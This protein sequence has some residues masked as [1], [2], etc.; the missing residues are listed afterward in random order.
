[1]PRSSHPLP[2]GDFSRIELPTREL[3]QPWFRL[4]RVARPAIY[5]GLN[6]PR[7]EKGRFDDPSGEYGVLYMASDPH[8]A[9]IE[10]FGH[11]TGIRTVEMAQLRARILYRI[12]CDRPLRLADLTGPRLAQ[13]GAD[14][15]IFSGDIAI[16]QQWSLAVYGHPKAPDGIYY[17]ARHDPSR[18]SAA[19]FNRGDM[20]QHLTAA[21]LGTLADRSNTGLLA[22]ILKSY[23]FALL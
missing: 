17:H 21:D 18:M 4:S 11:N 12:D 8:C 16:S 3:R 5:W 1:M 13:V 7:K 23:R 10:T 20:E 9:F 14:S 2:P 22:E 15:L 6:P 19:L